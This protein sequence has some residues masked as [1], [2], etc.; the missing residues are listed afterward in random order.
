M[1]KAL[2]LLITALL[3]GAVCLAAGAATV[4]VDANAAGGDGSAASPFGTLEAAVASLARTG[5]EVVLLSEVAFKDGDGISCDTNGQILVRAD[6]GAL[7]FGGKFYIDAPLHFSSVPMRFTAEIPMLFCEGNNVTF[8][9]GI[10]TSYVKYAPILYGGTYGGKSGMTYEK[11]CFADYTIRVD[12]GEWYYV[13]GGS[14]RDGEGQPVGTVSNVTLD[15][16]GGK[17]TSNKKSASDNALISPI[18]FDALLGDATLRISGGSFSASVVGISRPGYNSTTS[19]NQYARG[20]VY[21]TVSGGSFTGGDIRAVQDSVASQIDGNF[22]VDISGGSFQNFGGVDA[23]CVNGLALVSA[24]DGIAVKNADTLVT[25]R[26]GDKITVT[27]DALI[28]IDGEVSSDA[29]SI[30]KGRKVVIEGVSADAKITVKSGWKLAADTEIRNIV[31]NGNGTAAIDCGGGRVLFGENVGGNGVALKNFTDATLRSGL[32]AYLRGA[33]AEKVTLHID[34]A[35]VSDNAVVSS[36]KGEAYALVTAGSVGG[37]IY[38]FDSTGARGAVHLLAGTVGGKIAPAKT[39]IAD[40]VASFGAVAP[41]GAEI[42]YKGSAKYNAPTEAVFVKDGGTGDGTSPLSPLGDLAAAVKAADGKTVVVCGPLHLETTCT[43]PKTDKKTVITSTYMGMDYRDFFDAGITLSAG[44]CLGGETVLENVEFTAFEKYTYL[45]ANG[46][47][48]TVGEGVE[49]RIFEGKRVEKYPALIGAANGGKNAE[50]HIASGSWSVLSGGWYYT[51]DAV[52]TCTLDGDIS[53]TVTGGTFTEGVYLSGRA[54]VSGDALLEVY[55]GIFAC[56]VR[57]LYREGADILGKGEIAIYGG[58]FQGDILGGGKDFTLAVAGGDLRRVCTVNVLGKL[59]LGEGLDLDAK[60]EGVAEYTN[61]IAGYAD[62]SVVYHDGWYYYSFAKDY[63]GKPALWMA[64]APNVFDIGNAEA[65][66]VWAAATASANEIVSLWAPQLYQIDGVWYLYATCDVGL[67]AVSGTVRRMPIIWRALT[68]DPIGA[69][70]YIGRMQNTDTDVCSYL[71]PRLIEHGGKLYMFNGG[72]YRE[73]DAVGQHLQRMFGCELSDPLTMGTKP[74]VI[75]TPEYDYEAGIMEG[76]FPFYAPDG[77]LYMLFAAGHTRT[78]EYCTGLMRFVGGET[79]SLLDASKW[80]KSET[81]LH[82]V[83]YENG[84]YSPGAMVL[85]PNE[86]GEFFAVYHAKEYHYS[87]YTMR[88][89]Y[90]QKM[91]FANGVPALEAPLPTDTV[92]TEKL[93]SVPLGD[94]FGGATEYGRAEEK[95]APVLRGETQYLDGTVTLSDV[96]FSL[97]ELLDGE[98][99]TDVNGDGKCSLLDILAMLKKSTQ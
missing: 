42:S 33:N 29:I 15:I 41:L 9:E 10:T 43:L 44:L 60:V 27:E 85:V 65:V 30:A 66:L 89:L 31:L 32:F 14:F 88:R 35:T 3:C 78:D 25:L 49:C 2:L 95:T 36:G 18:G 8:G 1:K 61:P 46:Y 75:S 87:A 98:M 54:T 91:T 73:E 62:P 50:M 5:G 26:A 70:E 57:A 69:Y 79:D 97:R 71:S 77:T 92:F 51:A 72:F 90:V 6:G 48:L 12:S 37:S 93:A 59:C 23:S 96:L 56:P 39:P 80:V 94:R 11:M 34:G 99:Q 17:F 28:R 16:R 22:Y 74:V 40:G 19:N 63:L 81:P 58:A 21:I 38:T 53:L 7:T 45:L 67:A 24:Q 64:K 20:N 83:S 68:D 52:Q 55:G 4:Y 47:P 84:V 82:A 13:K 76:P 86:D